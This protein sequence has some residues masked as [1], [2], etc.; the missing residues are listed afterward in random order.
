ME[1]HGGNISIVKDQK[2]LGTNNSVAAKPSLNGATAMKLFKD[3]VW[4]RQDRA[5]KD[6]VHSENNQ[7]ANRIG[8]LA[9]VK[10]WQELEDIIPYL[11]RLVLKEGQST[12]NFRTKVQKW[13][14]LFI[15]C[16]DEE[17][18]IHYIVSIPLLDSIIFLNAS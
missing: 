6:I 15:K 4:L 2:K 9:R 13:E 12:A 16:F 8:Y 10:M 17:H 3:S 18:I 5:W 11:T 14:K 1:V 7:V